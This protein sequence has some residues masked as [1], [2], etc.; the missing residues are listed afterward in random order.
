MRVFFS[1]L[2]W[3]WCHE[4]IRNIWEKLTKKMWEFFPCLNITYAEL[5]TQLSSRMYCRC[6]AQQM[7]ARCSL[8]SKLAGQQE[9]KLAKTVSRGFERVANSDHFFPES[10]GSCI[11]PLQIAFIIGCFH[12]NVDLNPLSSLLTNFRMKVRPEQNGIWG[13]G[14]RH[15]PIVR[16]CVALTPQA[17]IAVS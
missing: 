15:K 6:S 3:C 14:G 9:G 12:G 16:S 1:L 4:I 7:G 17:W 13:S 5:Q 10:F 8:G 11:P 2:C